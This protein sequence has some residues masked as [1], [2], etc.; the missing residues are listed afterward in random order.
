MTV[1]VKAIAGPDPIG[2]TYLLGEIAGAPAASQ[3]RSVSNAALA[4]GTVTVAAEAAAL[5]ADVETAYA[6]WQAA[7]AALAEL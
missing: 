1:T 5:R 7:Q 6:N 2:F 3:V 4:A